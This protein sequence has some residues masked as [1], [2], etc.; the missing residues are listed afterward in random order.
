[1]QFDWAYTLS[2]LPPLLHAGWLTIRLASVI[3]ILGVAGGC[4]LTL[5]R[6]LKIPALSAGVAAVMSAVRGTPLLIQI[7]V[8]YYVLPSI[9]I[10]LSP[11][12]AGVLAIALNSAVFTTEIF[13]GGLATIEDGQIEAALSL[14]L[15]SRAIWQRVILPQVFL[16]TLPN[17]IGEYTIVVKATALLSVITVVELFRTSVRIYSANFHPFETLLA[18]ALVYM[19]INYFVSGL[20]QI[21]ERHTA[22]R[23]S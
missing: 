15:K 22:A 9:G 8:F 13:R 18:A 19:A 3:M 10:D 1:L 7:F 4:L 17:L 12:T 23:R 16:R 11:I 21:A 20:G 14:G 2:A 5:V 6:A